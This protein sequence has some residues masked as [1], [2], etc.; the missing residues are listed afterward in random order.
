MIALVLAATA[1]LI[2][3]LR[4]DTLNTAETNIAR[5][6]F[7][8][9]E[10]LER[11]FQ[12]IDLSLAEVA[13]EVAVSVAGGAKPAEAMRAKLQALASGLPAVQRIAY[14]D[15]S[16][17]VIGTSTNSV[18]TATSVADRGYFIAHRNQADLG[19]VVSEPLQSRADGGFLG[20]VWATMNLDALGR[21]FAAAAPEMDARVSLLRKDMVMLARYP[22]AP[23]FYGQSMAEAPTFAGI[24]ADG[25]TAGSGRYPSFL[26]HRERVAAARLLTSY[27]FVVC[28]AVPEETLLAPW[29]QIATGIGT[30]ALAVVLGIAA[31]FVAL[32]RQ[33]HWL[34]TGA[35]ALAAA[36]SSLKDERDRL[37]S[38]V[39]T[40]SD[41]F[42]EW[43]LDTGLVDWSENC[44]GQMGMPAAG[45]VLHI[46]QVLE[47]V[48]PADRER[49]RRCLRGHIDNSRPFSIEA[50]WRTF[51]GDVRW[52]VSR[53]RVIRDAAGRPLRVVGANSD[54]SERKL[55]ESVFRDAADESALRSSD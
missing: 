27:P 1:V 41:G 17:R 49:Y 30:A 20:V 29:R 25:R 22:E 52:M 53:G 19:F 33:R 39:A 32:H 28:L 47:M 13:R 2:Q 12:T 54:I 35:Q 10:D 7:I 43:H 24:F 23:A 21:L 9:A 15:A 42:W 40:A 45:G 34:R 4:E 36:E 26:D 14:S 51:D 11:V 46:E 6:N 3:S 38:V 8:L 5:V 44:C 18:L 50:R 31:L 55:L 16:G 48:E 37:S